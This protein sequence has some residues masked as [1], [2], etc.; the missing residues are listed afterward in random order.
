MPIFKQLKVK[1]GVFKQLKASFVR[2]FK[3]IK[4][5]FCT[6]FKQLKEQVFA[7]FKQLKASTNQVTKLPYISPGPTTSYCLLFSYIGTFV[8]WGTHQ[9]SYKPF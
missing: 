8:F 2:I 6:H 4:G 1:F 7:I 3:Q 9:P 5:N